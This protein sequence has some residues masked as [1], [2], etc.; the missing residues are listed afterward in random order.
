MTL[1]RRIAIWWIV[2]SAVL[3]HHRNPVVKW[4]GH[5]LTRAVR[6]LSGA[7][8]VETAG[9]DGTAG[10]LGLHLFAEIEWGGACPITGAGTARDLNGDDREV[11]YYARGEGWSLTIAKPGGDVDDDDA[12][13]YSR[14][15]YF[16]PD[17]GWVAAHI[18]EA[19]IR[20]A[21]AAWRK[22]GYP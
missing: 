20:E 16:H 21:L 17:G 1:R 6:W 4:L 2:K 8:P 9:Y 12:W 7:R 10:R 19:N 15:P 3:R 5:R 11:E 22:A 14:S 13:V 18:S